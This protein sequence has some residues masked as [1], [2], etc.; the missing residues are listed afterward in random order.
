VE[1]ELMAAIKCRVTVYPLQAKVAVGNMPVVERPRLCGEP[2]VAVV[3][4]HALCLR[5][6]QDKKRLSR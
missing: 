4:G 3:D 2:V 5:H 6:L 1:D